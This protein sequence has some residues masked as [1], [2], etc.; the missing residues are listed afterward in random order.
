MVDD[1]IVTWLHIQLDADETSARGLSEQTRKIKPDVVR[2]ATGV[3]ADIEAKRAILDA[4]EN[5]RSTYHRRY[6]RGVGTATERAT[7]Y[8]L[9][10]VVCLLANTYADRPGFREEWRSR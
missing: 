1:S 2:M 10:H 3:L 7:I 5:A 4:H 6:R 8:A 9:D